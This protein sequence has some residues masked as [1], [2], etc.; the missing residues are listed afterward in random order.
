MNG[1]LKSRIA[2]MC[3]ATNLKRADAL[4]LVLMLMRNTPERKTGLSPHEILMGRAMRLPVV[5]ANALVNI[6][7]D[8]VLDYGKGLADVVRS[9]SQ[10]LQANTLPPI[11]DPV[12]IVGMS[13]LDVKGATHT[14]A[15]ETTTLTAMEKFKLDE[16]S[17]HD[18]INAQGELS[19]NFFYRL[20]NTEIRDGCNC[21]RRTFPLCRLHS[22]PA[23]SWEGV[24]RW[25]GGRPSGGRPP[26]QRETQNH[27]G[28]LQTAERCSVGGTLAGGLRRPPEL[29]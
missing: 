11:H 9:F 29:E 23:S 8:M 6:T 12:V 5:P 20:L 19:S 22:E 18:Y 4:P 7:D 27:R 10:H 14:S 15:P 26:S 16:K 21:T 28:G 17:L 1:T 25:A 13:V 24:S 2:K 3:A